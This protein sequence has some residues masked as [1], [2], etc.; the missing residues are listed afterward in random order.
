MFEEPGSGVDDDAAWVG[1]TINL[2]AF[3]GQTI[4]VLI[5]VA[6]AANGSL[7]EAAVDDVKVTGQ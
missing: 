2:N 6:D 1:Q 7:V 5:E 4:R 3:T